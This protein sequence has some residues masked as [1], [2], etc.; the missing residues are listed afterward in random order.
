MSSSFL[1]SRESCNNDFLERYILLVNLLKNIASNISS[2]IS[3]TKIKCLKEYKD[4]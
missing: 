1:S 4:K 2:E 3:N